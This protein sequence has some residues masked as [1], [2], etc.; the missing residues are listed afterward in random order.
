MAILDAF[1][2]ASLGANWVE[3]TKLINPDGPLTMIAGLDGVEMTP[4]QVNSGY[5]VGIYIGQEFDFDK[6]YAE[7]E[8][9]DEVVFPSYTGFK[10]NYGSIDI[11]LNVPLAA[12]GS[13]RFVEFGFWPNM[14]T[15]GAYYR[16]IYWQIKS[17]GDSGVGSQNWEAY[18]YVVP[19]TFFTSDR[20]PVGTKTR[21][22]RI[23]NTYYAFLYSPDTGRWYLLGSAT[24]ATVA[25]YTDGYP[26][27]RLYSQQ[28]ASDARATNFRAGTNGDDFLIRG[29]THK[30]GVKDKSNNR[31]MRE[32]RFGLR[33]NDTA[34]RLGK[35]D[36]PATATFDNK[37]RNRFS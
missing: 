23:G 31:N 17:F 27:I 5:S 19:E 28:L 6:Q 14:Y 9:F 35:F 36:L 25:L 16:T 22:E 20:I 33:E 26:G 4:A 18:G 12:V 24:P 8:Y 1:D 11:A 2:R 34:Y 21:L 10:A 29:P 37:N 7:V 30:P 15:S 3:P 13:K 32:S